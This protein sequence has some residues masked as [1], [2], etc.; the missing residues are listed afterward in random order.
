MKTVSICVGHS[1]EGDNGAVSVSG[2]S[3]WNYN[4]PVAEILAG[5][6]RRAGVK[7]YVH[8]MYP[9]KDYSTAMSL[10]SRALDV[11]NPDCAIELHFNSATPNARGFEYLFWEMSAKGR[12]LAQA[13]QLEHHKRFPNDRD[14]GVKSIGFGQNG[15]L[16]LRL[17][18]CPCVICEPFFGSSE[19]DWKLYGNEWGQSDL[20]SMY[21]MALADFLGVDLRPQSPEDSSGDSARRK[22][23]ED[24]LERTGKI[25]VELDALEALIRTDAK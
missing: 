8:D 21:A 9:G 10:L 19:D 4:E 3:E 7:V 14:R 5:I 20:A 6:L 16:F 1:R 24:I 2:E 15:S 11:E 17:P 12:K 13:F 22:R 25:R 18:N 23:N